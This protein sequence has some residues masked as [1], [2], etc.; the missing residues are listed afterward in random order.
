M[1]K[2]S[3]LSLIGLTVLAVSILMIFFSKPIVNDIGFRYFATSNFASASALNNFTFGV[4]LLG[5]LLVGVGAGLFLF[6]GWTSRFRVDHASV[7]SQ[8][9]RVKAGFLIA[10]F[11]L[12]AVS[13]VSTQQ[14]NANSMSTTGYY[15][16][17]PYSP[18]D[19]LIGQYSTGLTYAINGSSWANMMTWPTPAP[20]ASLTDNSTAVIEAALAATTSGVVYLKGVAFDLALMNSIPANVQVIASVGNQT[21]T[22]CNPS[23]SQGSPYT[24]E[25]G[26]GQTKDY[27]TA[28][29]SANR[30]CWTSTNC[31]FVENNVNDALAGKGGTIII[32][33]GQNFTLTAPFILGC[34]DLL[35]YT[36]KSDA[37]SWLIHAPD[38]NFS[39]IETSGY[40]LGGFSN[41]GLTIS[42]INIDGN[43]NNNATGNGINFQA[44]YS[45]IQNTE[46]YSCG[47]A[48]I[49]LTSYDTGSGSADNHII[50]VRI[51]GNAA[52]G[53]DIISGA[54]DVEITN[55][56]ILLNGG[57]GVY[58][59]CGDVG[60][61]N[62]HIY[63]NKDGI[64][65]FGSLTS[66]IS[67][68]WIGVNWQ[69]DIYLSGG[70]GYFSSSQIISNNNFVSGNRSSFANAAI[71]RIDATSESP[72]TNVSIH[73]N[74]FNHNSDANTLWGIY[75]GSSYISGQIHSNQFNGTWGIGAYNE[76]LPAEILW[77]NNQGAML[78]KEKI[79]PLYSGGYYWS[80]T[81]MSYNGATPINGA[82]Y[83]DAY[84]AYFYVVN[85]NVP[86]SGGGIALQ[87]SNG[88]IVDTI[89]TNGDHLS[90]TN[91]ISY[92]KSAGTHSYQPVIYF[93]EAENSVSYR[94]AY[95]IIY[96]NY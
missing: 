62:N 81:N 19:W 25:V 55:S 79:I 6:I 13:M 24:I 10:A 28:K 90:T 37:T 2:N 21:L 71:I 14:V 49:R 39:M 33:S 12:V 50:S 57:A 7:H 70:T 64:A 85:L 38:T 77:Q 15:L 23:A 54:S 9:R 78:T 58:Q 84:A 73:D 52:D 44:F 45:L 36:L 76:P 41:Y 5:Y 87:D 93:A 63:M 72:V 22:F 4:A 8:M 30:I 65:I 48:G 68:N 17:T 69:Y 89:S 82:Y 35:K 46:I 95:I 43:R 32:A 31:S 60:L 67:N 56:Y 74:I 16:A 53:I 75:F 59:N 61:A 88:T 94:D 3:K 96:E 42:G 27:Y 20:W 26:Q 18:Y 51:S 83:P 47:G 11:L 40:S 66:Q 29:D 92:I 91:I 1:F 86:V 80:D 34:N